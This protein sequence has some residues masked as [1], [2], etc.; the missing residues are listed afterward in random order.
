M[1]P[2]SN[3]YV[4]GGEP[5]L[6]LGPEHAEIFKR[7]GP[8][9]GGRE[10][11]AVGAVEDA[12]SRACRRRTSSARAIRARRSSATLTPETLLPISPSAEDIMLIVAGGPGTHS[13]YV[14]CFGNRVR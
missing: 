5:W 9:Q 1:H 2:P 3:E 11:P 13:V 10:A 4:H 14:P 12:A 7:G 8:E 6:I